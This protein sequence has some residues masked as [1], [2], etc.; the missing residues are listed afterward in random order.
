LMARKKFI[1]GDEKEGAERKK[2]GQVQGLN[3]P[4]GYGANRRN[5]F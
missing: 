1:G 3:D 4:R 2:Q 5:L